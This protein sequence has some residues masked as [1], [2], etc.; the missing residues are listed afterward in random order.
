[1]PRMKIINYFDVN[2]KSNWQLTTNGLRS[3]VN[4]KV[5]GLGELSSIKL[6]INSMPRLTNKL[7][8]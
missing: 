6:W 3:R 4:L 8:Y 1:M 7:L 5:K 2:I